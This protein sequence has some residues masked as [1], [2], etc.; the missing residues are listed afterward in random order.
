[1]PMVENIDRK[2]TH[3][4]PK[5]PHRKQ[6]SIGLKAIPVHAGPIPYVSLTLCGYIRGTTSTSKPFCFP[7]LVSCAFQKDTGSTRNFA[8]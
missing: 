5:E 6:K 2:Q 7:Q 1:M 8:F 4:E 3:R